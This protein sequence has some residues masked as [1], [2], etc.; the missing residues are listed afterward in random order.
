[1]ILVSE[2]SLTAVKNSLKK[3]NS[4]EMRSISRN[5]LASRNAARRAWRNEGSTRDIAE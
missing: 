3:S 4:Q 5:G 1:M 2:D